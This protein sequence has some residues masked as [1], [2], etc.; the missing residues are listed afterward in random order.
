MNNL[1]SLW[2]KG[3]LYIGLAA[4]LML[5]FL[6]D[7]RVGIYDWAKEI[8]YFDYIRISLVRFHT[9]PLF[10][11]NPQAFIDYP[12]IGQS[13]FFIAN[14][15]TF[16]FSPFIL[17]LFLFDTILFMKIL[18]LLFFAIG[19]VGLFALRRQ[20]QWRDDQFRIFIALF[21]FSPIIIQ[22]VS[23]GYFPWLNIY[24]FP[25]LLF[26]LLNEKTSSQVVGIAGVLALTLLQGG[27]HVFWWFSLFIGLF[28]LFRFIYK[29][30][31]KLFLQVVLVVCLVVLLAGIRISTSAQTFADFQQTFFSGYN[32]KGFFTWAF[33]PPIFT[34]AN[35]DDIEPFIEGYIH[36]VPYWD[37]AVFW[38]FAL[39][40]SI[41]FMVLFVI[42]KIKMKD[43]KKDDD[44][45]VVFV[46]LSAILMTILSFENIYQNL[47]T[48]ISGLIKIPALEAI[49]KY[50]FRLAIPGYFGMAFAVAHFFEPIHLTLANWIKR[51]ATFFAKFIH[52][53]RSNEIRKQ[54]KWLL[55]IVA[56]LAFLLL[57]I[58]ILRAPINNWMSLA[59]SEAYQ[60]TGSSW[61]SSLMSHKEIISLYVYLQKFVDLYQMIL[62]SVIILWLLMCVIY[63]CLRF[64][65]HILRVINQMIAWAGQNLAYISEVLIVLPL[66][67]ASCM[68]LRVALATPT[69]SFMRI[70]M[71]PPQIQVTPASG[72]VIL[73]AAPDRLVI[74]PQGVKT[75]EFSQIKSSD[76]RFLHIL[77]SNPNMWR[78]GPPDSN[79][80][81]FLNSDEKINIIVDEEQYL[82]SLLITIIAW[83]GMLAYW[84]WQRW[85]LS[86]RHK[87]RKPSTIQ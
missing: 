66:L 33:I 56:I 47:I 35:M 73:Q 42:R 76:S 16:V 48:A 5:V 30:G 46:A 8:A 71:L 65:L 68:W 86:H 9:L 4:L 81:L 10:W 23:I 26:F 13:A 15:E 62:N 32:I 43:E 59:I 36:G 24:L 39:I 18:V 61:L 78:L 3:Y 67:L 7:A 2:R 40:L 64:Q 87:I 80:V 60:G 27:T 77:G 70:E 63:I 6:L 72:Q 31:F 85:K 37:G 58:I 57:F 41:I 51:L 50:P 53:N 11:W 1:Q 52:P 84:I 45:I 44:R 22:H 12:A 28:Y 79:L 55:V 14:P 74:Q 20:L 82:P 75:I 38:G 34:P 19:V 29:P 69:T 54:Y 17:L 21:L 83:L 49:E 25:W